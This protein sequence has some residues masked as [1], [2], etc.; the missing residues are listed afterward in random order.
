MATITASNPQ[1]TNRWLLI[2]AAVL[3][4]VAGILVAV[5]L[6]NTGGG[7]GGSTNT[8]STTGTSDQFALVAKETIPAGKKITLGMFDRVKVDSTVPEAVS[9]E[10]VAVGQVPSV[11]ILKGEQLSLSRIG[12][13]S[14]SDPTL[15]RSIPDGRV[16]AT[17]PVDQVKSISGLIVA[18]DHVD[19]IGT[20][21]EKRGD[22][23]VTRVETVL[24]N[25]QIL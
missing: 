6:A 14:K 17:I 8:K 21:K 7:G 2:G 19:L 1:R 12:L 3:A 4:L 20:F 11:E 13:G 23:D 9:D 15:A 5:V 22:Q 10:S 24:Q 25:V 18:G 16:A